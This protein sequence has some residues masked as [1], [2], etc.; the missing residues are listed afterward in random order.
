MSAR[1]LGAS[2]K[3]H[4]RMLHVSDINACCVCV[5]NRLRQGSTLVVRGQSGA[6]PAVTA[7]RTTRVTSGRCR[8]IGLSGNVVLVLTQHNTGGHEGDARRLGLSCSA[9]TLTPRP[10][11]TL[12]TTHL[13]KSLPA[14][15]SKF[16][17]SFDPK[18]FHQ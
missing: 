2:K 8:T 17:G 4:D 15:N 16:A 11:A 9:E 3:K 1:L 18:S 5:F 14:S 7:T 10:H 6:T 13:A 12:S